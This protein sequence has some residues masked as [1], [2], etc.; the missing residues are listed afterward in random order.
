MA[1]VTND[2]IRF[3]RSSR[4]SSCCGLADTL[5]GWRDVGW[6]EALRGAHRLVLVDAP[7]H[8]G[9]DRPRAPGTYGAASRSASA[10]WRR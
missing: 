5:D 4:G 6:V 3:T 2:G 10:V 9:S 8:G 7:G 1:Y